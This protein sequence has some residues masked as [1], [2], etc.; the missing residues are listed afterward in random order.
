MMVLEQAINA[1]RKRS[2]KYITKSVVGRG[3][4]GISTYTV[5]DIITM[6]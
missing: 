4:E 2:R 3:A 1:K 6:E 5:A